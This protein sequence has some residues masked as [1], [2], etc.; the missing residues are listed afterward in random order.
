[1]SAIFE[2]GKILQSAFP[3]GLPYTDREFVK[4]RYERTHYS[5]QTASF[6]D[7]L[8]A[9]ECLELLSTD[10]DGR[11]SLSRNGREFIAAMTVNDGNVL[12]DGNEGQKRLLFRCIGTRCMVKVCS[13][14]FQKFS[15]NYSSDPPAWNSY[16]HV[17]DE[18]ATFIIE[19]LEEVG[20]IYRNNNLVVI[21]DRYMDLFS[22]VKN[23]ALGTHVDWAHLSEYKKRIGDLGE[24]MAMKHECNRLVR[25]GRE[26]LVDMVEQTSLIDPYAGYDIRSF[27]GPGS[28]RGEHD[29]FIEVKATVGARPEFF[30]SR[31]EAD[32]ARLHGDRYWIY[33][34]TDVEG[35]SRTL[36]MIQNPYRE[37][38]MTGDPLPEPADYRI[39]EDV[40]GHA[41]MLT[42]DEM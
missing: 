38:F 12:L 23:K 33:L 3:D 31:N 32:K 15:I 8:Y 6:D 14:M 24:T 20:M 35:S 10:D 2:L 34:W 5:E 11:V 28:I 22:A 13:A 7:V 16:A 18:R 1:M 27:D 21:D 40:L 36:H 4:V 37:L 41:R 9:A 26:D 30:W 19:I 25:D 39:G 29:R 17:F 42:G